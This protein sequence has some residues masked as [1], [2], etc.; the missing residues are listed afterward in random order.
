[1]LPKFLQWSRP[2]KAKPKVKHPERRLQEDIEEREFRASLPPEILLLAWIQAN[3]AGK[4]LREW[5]A[6]AARK[7]LERRGWNA[8]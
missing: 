7:E 2:P 8:T 3:E 4:P 1:M 5:L 6:E